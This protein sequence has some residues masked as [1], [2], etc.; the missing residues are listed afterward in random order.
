ML[1]GCLLAGCLAVTVDSYAA[2]GVSLA[3][4][5]WVVPKDPAKAGDLAYQ[6][7]ADKV[8]NALRL[9]GITLVTDPD[10]HPDAILVTDFSISDPQTRTQTYTKPVVG[11]VASGTTT[12]IKINPLTGRQEAVVV[13]DYSTRI[14][15]QTTQTSTST[16]YVRR[17]SAEAYEAGAAPGAPGR[18]LWKLSA[19]SEGRSGDLR[20]TLPGLLAASIPWFGKPTG[21][22]VSVDL[23][24]DDPRV[25]AVTTGVPAPAGK[26]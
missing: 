21:K 19:T 26:R 4:R 3:L 14:V 18:Q 22:L 6:E 8:R 25:T 24:A 10:Q 5:Y 20:Q 2:P 9:A 7:G 15:G 11:Q 13:P 17:F 1:F 23:R 12:E 16:V